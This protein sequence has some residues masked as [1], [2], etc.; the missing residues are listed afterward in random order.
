MRW[1]GAKAT[2]KLTA[3]IAEL[4]GVFAV[5]VFANQNVGTLE[6]AVHDGFGLT[7]VQVGN[8]VRDVQRPSE[9]QSETH[10]LRRV[11]EVPVN[12]DDD[13]G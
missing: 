5:K 9:H 4:E 12:G 10:V 8:P 6:V 3:E 2:S 11:G 7:L 1:C 13:P